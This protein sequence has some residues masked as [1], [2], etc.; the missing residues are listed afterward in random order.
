MLDYV[1][2]FGAA[3]GLIQFKGKILLPSKCMFVC[4]L[5]KFN[6]REVPH[7]IAAA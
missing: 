1:L 4:R 2:D 6:L 5:I 7:N 3:I